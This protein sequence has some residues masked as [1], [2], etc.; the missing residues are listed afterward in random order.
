MM[1]QPAIWFGDALLQP[2]ARLSDRSG[3]PRDIHQLA[4][5]VV[6]S[7]QRGKRPIIQ[8]TKLS[9]SEAVEQKQAPL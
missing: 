6:E 4:R 8:T 9:S 2:D 1:L 7:C 3:Q 5:E